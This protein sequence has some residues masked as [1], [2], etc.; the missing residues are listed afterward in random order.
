MEEV[1]TKEELIKI[2][3]AN[4]ENYNYTKMCIDDV[5][6]ILKLMKIYAKFGRKSF[7]YI[8]IVSGLWNCIRMEHYEKALIKALNEEMPTIRFTHIVIENSDEYI[9]LIRI[10]WNECVSVES[11]SDSDEKEDYDY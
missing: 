6:I 2:S 8:P 10:S 4:K 3:D 9:S 7:D 1:P 11:T 5:N